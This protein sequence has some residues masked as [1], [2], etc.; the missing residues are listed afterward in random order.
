M[1]EVTIKHLCLHAYLHSLSRWQPNTLALTWF[2]ASRRC[3]AV[4]INSIVKDRL[5]QFSAACLIISNCGVLLTNNFQ[6]SAFCLRSFILFKK[7]CNNLRSQATIFTSISAVTVLRFVLSTY[8]DLHRC[9][10]VSRLNFIHSFTLT[11][12][13][14]PKFE[15]C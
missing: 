13:L 15:K 3:H 8:V 9:V 12:P 5:Q 14:S 2:C 4:I 11:K 6:L 1:T 10:V 7:D